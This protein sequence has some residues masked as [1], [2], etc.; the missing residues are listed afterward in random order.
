MVIPFLPR[1]RSQSPRSDSRSAQ[2]AFAEL[3]RPHLQA[4]YRLAY[5]F[6]GRQHEAED[7]LQELLTRLYARPE[8]LNGIE[9]LRPWLA[10]A[11]YNLYVDERR[12]LAR[13]PLGHLHSTT[14]GGTA[15]EDA[16]AVLPDKNT[17]LN[18]STEMV[19]MRQHLVELVQQLPQEQREVVIL[20]DVEGYELQEAAE[21]LGVALGTVK[22]RL[23]RGHERLRGWLRQRNLSPAT[24]VLST[25]GPAVEP[26]SP[27]A[28]VSSDEMY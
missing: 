3:V 24:V 4:L 5:R 12:R 16:F 14:A 18:F 10:R 20:H 23:H 1:G 11:L 7:L 15:Q 26:E 27:V 19:Q 13:S 22:S 2:D 21:I 8:R 17:D 6:T 28:R 25:E 9:S